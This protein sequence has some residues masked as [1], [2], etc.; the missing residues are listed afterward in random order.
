VQPSDSRNIPGRAG[1][2]YWVSRSKRLEGRAARHAV[3]TL[4][5][6]REVAV[7]GGL[8]CY[9]GGI[10]EDYRRVGIY[11][12]DSLQIGDGDGHNS[13]SRAATLRTKAPERTRQQLS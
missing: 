4:Y 11:W 12:S 2:L 9:V 1:A 8:M 5:V 6:W 7:G 10:A 13:A 3:P